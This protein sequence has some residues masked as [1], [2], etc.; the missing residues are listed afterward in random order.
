MLEGNQ[1]NEE[2]KETARSSEIVT[3]LTASI[4]EEEVKK[5]EEPSISKDL[6]QDW[7]SLE[8]ELN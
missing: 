1:E 7:K 5:L 2:Q 4:I 6:D 3:P 8:V